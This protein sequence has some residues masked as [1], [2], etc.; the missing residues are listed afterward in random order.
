MNFT[1]S[2]RDKL[3]TLAKERGF[4]DPLTK[5]PPLSEES[6]T[7]LLCYYLN[8]K[9]IVLRDVPL[10]SVK[11]FTQIKE[12]AISLFP[13]NGIAVSEYPLIY[14]NPDQM[15]N[16]GAMRADI[17]YIGIDIVT[18]IEN[19]IGSGFTY[20]GDK[21]VGQLARQIDFLI[22]AKVPL[23]NLILLSSRDMF[24]RPWYRVEFKKTLE[25]KVKFGEV[26]GYLM[27]WEDVID[28]V[29]KV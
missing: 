5:L 8:S 17:M 9:K 12:K 22:H 10:Y 23:R 19:K 14:A 21:E 18:M 26:S 25:F 20:G 16:W 27:C 13:P 29:L 4:I 6:L 28:K 24:N 1:S 2:V 11:E 3:F 15:N 7:G